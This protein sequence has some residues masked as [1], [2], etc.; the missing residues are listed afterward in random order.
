MA[1]NSSAEYVIIPTLVVDFVNETE[2]LIQDYFY[3]GDPKSAAVGSSFP[4]IHFKP[5][6][7]HRASLASVTSH[8]D[9]DLPSMNASSPSQGTALTASPS[10]QSTHPSEQFNVVTPNSAPTRSQSRKVGADWPLTAE[11]LP[12]RGMQIPTI[13]V[14]LDAADGPSDPRLQLDFT[15]PYPYFRFDVPTTL[16]QQQHVGQCH[17]CPLRA[18][19][20]LYAGLRSAL[21]QFHSPADRDPAAVDIVVSDSHGHLTGIAALIR[22]AQ[23]QLGANK[24]PVTPV[25]R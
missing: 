7:S 4:G 12:T 14:S 8:M 25:Q 16:S 15:S 20:G 13:C 10:A 21:I 18:A 11:S 2:D 1:S 9:V 6:P 19:F 24:K 22:A 3:D 17:L 5:P 23:E